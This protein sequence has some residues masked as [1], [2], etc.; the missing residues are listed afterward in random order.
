MSD[1][2]QQLAGVK[3]QILENPNVRQAINWYEALSA[4]DQLI[5]KALSGFIA[6][7]LFIILVIQPL[8]AN[9]E[10]YENRLNK[11]VK[12]YELLAENAHKFGPA[13]KG[14]SSSG[15]PV[16]ATVTAEAKRSGIELKRFEPDNDGLRVWLENVSFDSA[17][18]WLEELTTTHGIQISQI[19]VD[20]SGN[21]GR[22][23]IRASLTR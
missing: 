10:T 14:G 5:V 20:R 21:P 17:I 23:N 9:Q 16:L 1:V 4:R 7:C 12:T 8:I 19:N 6:V 13:K 18:R 15:G 3:T 11:S 22:V 2:K